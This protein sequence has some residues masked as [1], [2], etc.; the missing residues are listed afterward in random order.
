MTLR[1][2]FSDVF[3]HVAKSLNVALW[4]ENWLD[5]EI[6]YVFGAIFLYFIGL[7]VALNAYDFVHRMVKDEI[8]LVGKGFWKAWLKGFAIAIACFLVMMGAF[9]ILAE[10][11]LIR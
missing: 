7:T 2:L 9:A 1:D 10:F 6:G 5:A 4:Q 11:D 8:A 3:I